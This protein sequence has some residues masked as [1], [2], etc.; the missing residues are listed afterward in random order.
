MPR[1]SVD[2]YADSR[3]MPPS[4]HKEAV[5][6]KLA[7]GR[8]HLEEQGH[9]KPPLF[10]Y[11]DG[12]VL[13]LHRVRV[14]GRDM[15]AAKPDDLPQGTTKHVDVCGTI[16]EIEAWLKED[17]AGAQTDPE[18]LNELLAHAVYMC[19][20]MERRWQAYQAFAGRVVD[21]ANQMQQIGGPDIGQL[22]IDA[23]QA[24][25]LARAGEPTTPEGYR[26]VVARVEA[27]RDVANGL[28]KTLRQYRDAATALAA[29]Y[30]QVRGARDWSQDVEERLAAIRGAGQDTDDPEHS[31]GEAPSGRE[32]QP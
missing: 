13:E 20:R 1:K 25:A 2:E 16:D 9:G 10:V 4:P 17:P 31:Q 27:I 26:K 24:A 5:L 22:E 8:A 18:R 29:L 7:A 15:V 11:E 23:E 32:S 6:E 14:G 3:W 19:R 21:L 28:E 30:E 12:G